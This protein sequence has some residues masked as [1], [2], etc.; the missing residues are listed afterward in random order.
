MSEVAKKIN[1]IWRHF[2][3]E[4][5]WNGILFFCAFCSC[6]CVFGFFS[7]GKME[8][9]GLWGKNMDEER[10]RGISGLLCG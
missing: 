1:V 2:L 6:F 4:I 10:G 8:E 5:D 9:M 3:V 7:V